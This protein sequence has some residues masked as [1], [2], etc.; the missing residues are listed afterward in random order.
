[1][2]TSSYP[3]GSG[4]GFV[5]EKSSLEN[6]LSPPATSAFLLS[7]LTLDPLLSSFSEQV[8]LSKHH[9]HQGHTPKSNTVEWSLRLPSQAF[10]DELRTQQESKAMKI[11]LK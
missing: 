9:E 4:M 1:M 7:S 6:V 11:G 2:V 3:G 10:G 5:N 8:T